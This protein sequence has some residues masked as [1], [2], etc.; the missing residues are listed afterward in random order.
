MTA[1]EI[2]DLPAVLKP[3]EA[4]ELLRVGRN[5][6]YE[7]IARGEIRAVRL[8]RTIRIPRGEIAR[9]LGIEPEAAAE[10]AGLGDLEPR[11]RAEREARGLGIAEGG[12][13]RGP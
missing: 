11:T 12:G 13:R 9:L 7:A 5:Q 2:E 10:R 6:L 1:G 8:G 4:S 3:R